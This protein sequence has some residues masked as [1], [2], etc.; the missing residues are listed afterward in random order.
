MAGDLSLWR[1]QQDEHDRL[2]VRTPEGV[3][4]GWLCLRTGRLTIEL[5]GAAGE[6]L[7]LLA[8]RPEGE[9]ALA[10]RRTR[11]A[12][13]PLP[14]PPPGARQAPRLTPPPPPG[15]PGTRSYQPGALPPPPCEPVL[16]PVLVP[17]GA[18]EAFDGAPASAQPST[19]GA[20]MP[21]EAAAGEA[22][23]TGARRGWR[24]WGR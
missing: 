18:P 9:A 14:P 1:S 11:L 23:A 10:L 20:G 8:A 21:V 5:P 7:R 24:G 13:A 12:D 2:Y 16:V 3:T 15:A 19:A 22:D 17:V 6:V 4:A